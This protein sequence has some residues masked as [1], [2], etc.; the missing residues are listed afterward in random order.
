MAAEDADI[1]MPGPEASDS[2]TTEQPHN[3]ADDFN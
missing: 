3:E 2:E 1:E